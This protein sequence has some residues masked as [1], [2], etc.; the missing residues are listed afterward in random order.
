MSHM[1]LMVDVGGKSIVII[2]GG[3]VAE[4]RV[5]LFL[6]QAAYITVVSPE[7]APSLRSMADAGQIDWRKKCFDVK[8]I[9]HA[10]IIVA[11]TNN[12]AL[13]QTICQSASPYTLVN[14]AS[15][16]KGGTLHIPTHF[17]QGKLSISVSTNGAS[18]MLTSKIKNDLKSQYDEQYG[19]YVD[20]LYEMRQFMKQTSFIKQEQRKILQSLLSDEYLDKD[21]QKEISNWLKRKTG[22]NDSHERFS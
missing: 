14:N 16:A 7:V 13:N 1:P 12:E 18:P 8:D 3:N 11:A 20:F 4:R 2:G 15:D 5:S 21:R 17:Q 10:F 6:K 19:D 22:R 9:Q